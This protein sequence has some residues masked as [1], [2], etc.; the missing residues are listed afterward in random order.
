MILN[1]IMNIESYSSNAK[2][3]HFI[4]T[5]DKNPPMKIND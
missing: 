1:I 3:L 2:S 4:A 5:F